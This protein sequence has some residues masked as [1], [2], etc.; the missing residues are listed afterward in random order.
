MIR[1]RQEARRAEQRKRR[2][3]RTEFVL[4][5][6]VEMESDDPMR[7]FGDSMVEMIAS[8]GIV[9]AKGLRRLLDWYLSVNCGESRGMILEAFHEV[10]FNL[11]I[12]K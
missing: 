11:F 8:A 1:E 7:D 9:D 2:T 5:V 6:A 12:R 3:G 4:I 10:C